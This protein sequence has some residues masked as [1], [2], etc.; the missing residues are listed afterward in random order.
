MA[1]DSYEARVLRIFRSDSRYSPDAYYF[2][3]QAL[4]FTQDDLYGQSA[5][6]RRL[7]E[8]I[9]RYARETFGPAA[10]STLA[11]LGIHRC[12]D[13]GEIVF[14]LVDAGLIK[15]DSG[16]SRAD[17]VG[18]FDFVETFPQP[19]VKPDLIQFT[20]KMAALLSQQAMAALFLSLTM[21]AQISVLTLMPV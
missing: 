2:V 13:F 10:R 16:D 7:L 3:S 4:Q 9:R 19:K 20:Q 5:N 12:E 21:E 18:A 14:N 8:G 1:E 15:A 6:G 17:F 11:E